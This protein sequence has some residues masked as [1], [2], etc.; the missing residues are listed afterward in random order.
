MMVVFLIVLS[1]LYP[2]CLEEF[3]GNNVFNKY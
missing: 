3:L 1:M 2:L